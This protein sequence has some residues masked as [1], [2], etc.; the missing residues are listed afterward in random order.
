MHSIFITVSTQKAEADAFAVAERQSFIVSLILKLSVYKA[1]K[2]FSISR[3]KC[4][5]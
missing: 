4:S 2:D 5:Y 1:T 3:T